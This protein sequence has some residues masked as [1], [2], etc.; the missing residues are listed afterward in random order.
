MTDQT[1]STDNHDWEI[2]APGYDADAPT[3]AELYNQLV[4]DD[5]DRD[6]LIRG[7]FSE[8]PAAGEQ[9]R[10]FLA[11][12]RRILFYDDGSQWEPMAGVGTEQNPVPGTSHFEAVSTDGAVVDDTY[13]YAAF[14]DGADADARL[15]NAISTASDGDVIFLEN[16]SYTASRTLSDSY[17]LVGTSRSGGTTFQGSGTLTLNGSSTE[18]TGVR[19]LDSHSI[20]AGGVRTVIENVVEAGG[21]ITVSANFVTLSKIAFGSVTFDSGT[22]DGVI[23]SSTSVNITDNGN[24]IVGDTT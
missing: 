23:D 10:W 15:D 11:T 13:H 7:P 12:D 22:K 19:V 9:D 1:N 18:L 17:K 20:I 2:P 16:A 3:Y 14:Y 6:I 24:N 21:G 5:L 8:R 4:Q